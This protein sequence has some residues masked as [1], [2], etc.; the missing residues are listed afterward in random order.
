MRNLADN[1]LF[2]MLRVELMMSKFWN[3][4]LKMLMVIDIMEN[5]KMIMFITVHFILVCQRLFGDNFFITCYFEL[6]LS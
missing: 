2:G 3:I 1:N 4:D 6:K 5:V